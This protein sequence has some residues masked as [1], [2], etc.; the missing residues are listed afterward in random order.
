MA[1]PEHQRLL[2]EALAAE[3]EAQSKLMDGHHEEAAATYAA[4]ADLYRR[5]WDGAHDRA[6]GRLVGALKASVLAGDAAETAAYVRSELGDDFDSAASAYA[7]ALAALVEADDELAARAAATMAEGGEAFA[8]TAGAI[9]AIAQVDEAGYRA[10]LA[11]VLA[12]FEG[13]EEFLTRVAIADTAVVL[14]R[15]ARARDMTAGIRSELLPC[16]A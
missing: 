15:L 5:S 2:Q 14:E 13:R 3:A 6:F 8:S 9:I 11:T 12:D 16:D 4:V 1:L 10:A 7:V